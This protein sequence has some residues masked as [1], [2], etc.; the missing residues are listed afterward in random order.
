[1]LYTRTFSLSLSPVGSPLNI[2][3]VVPLKLITNKVSSLLPNTWPRKPSESQPNVE[4]YNSQ[5]RID[6]FYE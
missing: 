4:F 1:M 6:W 5:F 3:A 2:P